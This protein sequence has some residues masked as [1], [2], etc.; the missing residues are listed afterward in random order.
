MRTQR[1][2][3]WACSSRLETQDPIQGGTG[4]DV[5]SGGAGSDSYLLYGGMGHDTANDREGGETNLV[6]HRGRGTA[7]QLIGL[8]EQEMHGEPGMSA[9]QQHLLIEVRQRVTAI[10]DHHH[11]A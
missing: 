11:A 10:H 1:R 6:Q 8:G 3:C 5:L 9:P 4:D 2:E 7:T